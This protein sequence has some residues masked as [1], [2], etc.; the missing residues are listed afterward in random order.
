MRRLL[1]FVDWSVLSRFDCVKDSF[2]HFYDVA[3]KDYIRC[4]KVKSSVYYKFFSDRTSEVKR[5]QK[6][7]YDE[8]I[9]TVPN[10]NT[11]NPGNILDICQE[12]KFGAG[13][14]AWGEGAPCHRW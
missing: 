5:L 4:G 12:K 1:T 2:E 3:S 10:N 7:K 14:G 6:M 8:F 11:E 13:V 9:S